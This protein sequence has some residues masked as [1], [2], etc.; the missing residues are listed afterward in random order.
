MLSAEPLQTT[1]ASDV[2]SQGKC[3]V[4]EINFIFN[5]L[6]HSSSQKCCP[7]PT[8]GAFMD[9]P[10]FIWLQFRVAFLA[11]LWTVGK[12]KYKYVNQNIKK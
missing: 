2:E 8:I 6:I 11:S 12:Y 7:C 3:D 9:K 4:R 10:V 5:C 1:K